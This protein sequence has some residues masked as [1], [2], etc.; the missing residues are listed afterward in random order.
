MEYL[1][2]N[3]EDWL[4]EELEASG[5]GVGCQARWLGAEQSSRAG[6][7]ARQLAV[8]QRSAGRQAR[9]ARQGAT[10]QAQK[11]GHGQTYPVRVVAE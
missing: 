3:L 10:I 5:A 9:L 11:G 1:E 4:A 6:C 2:E 8:Q 7:R